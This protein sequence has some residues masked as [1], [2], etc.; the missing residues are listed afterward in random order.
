MKPLGAILVQWTE[1]AD[2]DL[3]AALKYA[4]GKREAHTQRLAQAIFE[5]DKTLATFPALGRPGQLS[6]TRELTLRELPFFIVY[7][8]QGEALEVLR[9]M[10]TSRQWPSKR[11]VR[12]K[13]S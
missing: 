1:A 9:L 4:G 3:D 6:G 12:K 2:A 8:Y 10:H 5:A 13:Q 7:R 11:P